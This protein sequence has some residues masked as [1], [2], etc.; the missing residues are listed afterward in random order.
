L[1]KIFSVPLQFLE[2]MLKER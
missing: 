1:S 2:I